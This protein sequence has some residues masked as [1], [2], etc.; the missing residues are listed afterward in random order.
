MVFSYNGSFSA[1]R[2]AEVREGDKS[3]YASYVL[4]ALQRQHSADADTSGGLY[5]YE[6]RD[7]TRSSAPKATL[8]I[9]RTFGQYTVNIAIIHLTPVAP[10]SPPSSASSSS[11]ASTYSRSLFPLLH[12]VRAG[13]SGL[14]A[15]DRRVRERLKKQQ[16]QLELIE[17]M[18]ADKSTEAEAVEEEWLGACMRL[19]NTE[20]A[21]IREMRA[22]TDK[23]ERETRA[24]TAEQRPAAVIELS[25]SESEKEEEVKEVEPHGREEMKDDAETAAAATDEGPALSHDSSAMELSLHPDSTS[26]PSSLTS[27]PSLQPDSSMNTQRSS[28][29]TSS[30]ASSSSLSRMSDGSMQSGDPSRRSVRKRARVQPPTVSPQS[31]PSSQ[32]APSIPT[33]LSLS[34]SLNGASRL[35]PPLSAAAGKIVA[36]TV[37]APSPA[38]SVSTAAD[39]RQMSRQGVTALF[40]EL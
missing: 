40:D 10:P 29:T 4:T 2:P 33:S 15:R 16:E 12:S 1:L 30:L 31:A 9:A 14:H 6:W 20:K 8:N 7:A 19:L 13:I 22:K 5:S 38:A 37:R 25:E 36:P 28:S 32:A 24:L 27:M 34:S 11:S 23:V 18:L 35:L 39:G 21:K 17:L 26:P 3:L